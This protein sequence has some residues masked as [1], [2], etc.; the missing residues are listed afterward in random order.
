LDQVARQ[1]NRHARACR[2]HPR[3]SFSLCSKQG[4]DGRDKPG[5]DVESVSIIAKVG[6]AGNAV[7][8]ALNGAVR[9]IVKEFAADARS[10][11]A[12]AGCL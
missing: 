3:L 1:L 11:S 2:G 9:T 5:H 4:V 10:S 12:T 7:S 6:I 8:T